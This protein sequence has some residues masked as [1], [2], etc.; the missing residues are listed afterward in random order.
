M[1]EKIKVL[2]VIHLALSVGLILVYAIIGDLNALTHFSFKSVN[3]SNIIFLFV[4]V[5]AILLGHFLFYSQIKK[6]DSRLKLEEKFPA[7]QTAL[8]L[9]WAVLEGAAFVIL[10]LS[11]GFMIFGVFIILYFLFLRPTEDRIKLDLT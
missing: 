7:Y 8:I 6:I 4:P 3:T 11:P 10:F 2:K 1:E 5:I 9:R